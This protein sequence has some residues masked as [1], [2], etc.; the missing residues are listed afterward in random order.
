MTS[1]TSTIPALVAAHD[2]ASLAILAPDR[3]PLTYGGLADRVAAAAAVFREAGIAPGDRVAIVMPD[4]A[5]LATAFLAIA[6]AATAAPLNPSYRTEEFDYYLNDLGAKALVVLEGSETPARAAA[7]ARG[8][9]IIELRPSNDAPAG[10]FEL[11]V[12][13]AAGAPVSAADATP[14][15][16]ALVLHTSGTTSKPKIVPLS[17]LNLT[18]SARNIART[19][20]LTQSD[21]GLVIMPLFHIHGLIGALLSSIAAGASVYCGGGFNALRF[22]G[23]LDESTATWYSAVP[24]MH[25]AILG[26]AE[27]N[28]EVMERHRLRLIRSSSAPMSP[29]LIGELEQMFGCPVIE[30]YGMTEAAHQMASN[31]LPPAARKPGSVGIAAGP[32]VAILDASGKLAAPGHPGEIVIRG[33]NVTGGYENRPEANA[34]AF[35]NG[36]FRTGDL[37]YLDD[38]GYLTISGRL[39]EIINRGGEKISPREVDDIIAEHPAVLQA[40]TFGMPSE[41]LGEEVAAAVVLREGTAAT[42]SELREFVAARLAPFKVPRRIVFLE[43]IPKGPTGKL[44]R[45]GLAERLGITR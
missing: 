10:S 35:R 24:S 17:H 4:S 38:E 23:W 33:P 2:P 20:S 25:Q 12:E 6:S 40:L 44:Q 15:D 39:K 9:A 3:A 22:F 32:E 43:E 42:E 18:T 28:R 36:W 31:P 5:E 8:V 1:V 41:K 13:R 45:I 34:E 19:L 7:A 21:R 26:R 11:I 14:S 29:V 16:I 37:G 27:R 30:S